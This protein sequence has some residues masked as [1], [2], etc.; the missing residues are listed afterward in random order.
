MQNHDW[1]VDVLRDIRDYAQANGLPQLLPL[2]GAACVMMEREIG[3]VN[4]APMNIVAFPANSDV[5]KDLAWIC[6]PKR[7]LN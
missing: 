2:I 1:L 7:N 5:I 3:P 6:N 4:M